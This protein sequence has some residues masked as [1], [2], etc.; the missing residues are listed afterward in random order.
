[1]N[2]DSDYLKT[3]GLTMLEGRW[4]D[5]ENSAD[6]LNVVLNETAVKELHIKEPVIGQRF[7]VW[8]SQGQ[9]IGIVKDFHF[10]SMHHKIGPMVL[11]NT[12]DG[13]AF[14]VFKSQS[15]K[16]NASIEAAKQVWTQFFPDAPFEV[17]YT[18]DV[19]NNLY[20]DDSKL[21]Q[22][23]LLLSLLSVF[24]SC[25]GLFGLVT[26]TAEAKTKEIGIRKVMG[27]SVSDI[28]TMLSK[29]F[30][31]LV[32]VGMVIAFPIAYYWLDKMLQNYAYRIS[33]NWWM[34]VMSGIIVVLLT[35]LTVGWQSLLLIL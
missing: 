28:V 6:R 9:V 25:L 23:V 12:E 2:V 11:T 10:N 13:N 5:A 21:A 24:I 27:A 7:S 3:N 15:G 19:F 34:F 31:I 30:L 17:T 1:M 33:I 16:M 26:F 20:K 14:V 18:D 29:E 35:L 22:I 32:G 8:G 4:F